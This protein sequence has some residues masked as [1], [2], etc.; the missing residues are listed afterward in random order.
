MGKNPPQKQ[1]ATENDYNSALIAKC[2]ELGIEAIAITDHWN[3]R[4]GTQLAK[5]AAEAGIAAFLGFEANSQEGI[6]ALVVFEVGTPVGDIDATIGVCGG[7][8]GADN[9]TLGKPLLDIIDAMVE[10][11]ALVVPAHANVKNSGLLSVLRGRPLERVVTTARLH[12][13][14]ISPAKPAGTDQEAIFEGRSPYRRPH[15]LSRIHA[16]DICHPSTLATEGA[17]T[18]FKVSTLTLESFKLAVRTPETRVSLVRPQSAA[19]AILRQI[20]WNG[21]LLHEVTLPLSSELTT[22]IGGRG[23]GKST[24][25]ESI[26][27]ALD[28]EPIGDEAKREHRGIVKDVLRSGTTVTLD[29]DVALPQPGRY[30]IRRSVDQVPVVLD[31][32]GE[33]TSLRPSDITG[34]VEIYGQH[35]LAELTQ[36]KDAV[37]E[38]LR[39]FA[40]HG[41]DD[42]ARGGLLKELK[43][44]RR[45]LHDSE[46]DLAELQ[47]ELDDIPRLKE[48]LKQYNES[49]LPKRLKEQELLELERAVFKV[50]TDRIKAAGTAA[51][52]LTT[53]QTMTA[54][55]TAIKLPGETPRKETLDLASSVLDKVATRIGDLLAQLTGEL[56]GA[57]AELI[58]IQ[59]EWEAQ[60]RPLSDQHQE[61]L[62]QLTEAKLEPDKYLAV[63]RKLSELDAMLPEQTALNEQISALGKQ[64][65]TL[66]AGL[67][68][69]QSRE[70]GLLNDAVGKANK[71]TAGQVVVRPT[72]STER[73]QIISLVERHVAGART[74]IREAVNAADFSP[75]EFVDAARSGEAELEN[76][77][78]IKGAQAKS[79]VAAGEELFRQIEE[80][81]I[82]RAVDVLLKTGP[83]GGE[84]LRRLTELSKGQRATALLMLLL[85]V[86][87]SAL[88]I[89]QPEDDLDNRFVYDGV[90]QKLRDLKG[91]RQLILAT[92]NA[93][94]PV[95]GDA[96][97]VIALEG[98]GNHSAPAADGVGSLD[99][100]QIK[101]LAEDILEGGR[102]AFEAR[103]HLYGF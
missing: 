26:R 70:N 67:T 44:N 12:A 52:N 29:V 103:Q 15:P 13:I 89:D 37:A 35:E 87:D 85:G 80:Q 93:N 99:S 1:Y 22:L 82:P 17:T 61:T 56:D 76:K 19:R 21:G 14:G 97:L 64:R 27:F 18:Y 66:L 81:A 57:L 47:E 58:T 23:T 33:A 54:L 45:L 11:G 20:S 91:R 71:A 78:S 6:H 32:A 53:T 39:R 60:T 95:L 16:D 31:A 72:P 98:D 42:D 50:G 34:N 79:L 7:K 63:V 38:M 68:E 40:G 90:V 94:V 96:E 28:S 75:R 101:V 69:S 24:V 36:D 41:L 51:S 49:E 59:Q 73:K 46:K 43:E 4:S 55:S 83:T 2:Q 3:A 88:I 92:H 10:H 5:D 84:T 62:R 86:P 74:Q 8:P 48:Q 102:K 9:G 100:Q 25:I 77:Y 65:L 30:R